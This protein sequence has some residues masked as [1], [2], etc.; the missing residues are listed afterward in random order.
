MG[1]FLGIDGGGSR[2]QACLGDERGHVLAKAVAG[3]SNPT[4]VGIERAK[5]ELLRAARAVLREVSTRAA[6]D[7]PPLVNAARGRRH[8]KPLLVAVCAGVAGVDRAAVSRP[9]LAWL[10]KAVPARHHLLVTDAE[11]ALYAAIGTAGELVQDIFVITSERPGRT[12]F[13]QVGPG[14]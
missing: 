13:V 12:G 5:K 6:R 1:L 3:P 10:R 2:T 8:H 14:T 9:L 7:E 4:K 11:I